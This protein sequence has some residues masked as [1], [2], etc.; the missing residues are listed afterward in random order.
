VI[1]ATRSAQHASPAL[2]R[3]ITIGLLAGFLSGMFGVGGGVLIVPALVILI[4]MHQRIAHGTSLAAVV[5]I[6]AVGASAYLL[7]GS[8]D[9]V[10]AGL[11]MVG[12]VIGAI[13]GVR[14]L[15]WLSQS[16]LRW[17]F[18]AFMVLVAMR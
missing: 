12:T 16:W 15:S 18:I 7:S 2:S 17:L 4:G 6:S 9:L 1:P 14:L 11:L 13:W 5:P 3:L 8:I 10:A